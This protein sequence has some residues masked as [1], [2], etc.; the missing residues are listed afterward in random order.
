M[1]RRCDGLFAPGAEASLWGQVA[2]GVLIQLMRPNACSFGPPSYASLAIPRDRDGFYDLSNS[3]WPA[4]CIAS[5]TA[6]KILVSRMCRMHDLHEDSLDLLQ[7]RYL[8]FEN[9][10]RIQPE[11]RPLTLRQVATSSAGVRQPRHVQETPP[12][13]FPNSFLSAS[14]GPSAVITVEMAPQ[15]IVAMTLADELAGAVDADATQRQ[16]LVDAAPQYR[17]MAR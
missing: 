16:D 12:I 15:R 1:R 7:L 11:Y 3:T 8:L 17:A 14:A 9:N 4:S 2:N 10:L 5:S 6:T 13:P